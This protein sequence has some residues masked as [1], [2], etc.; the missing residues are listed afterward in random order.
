MNTEEIEILDDEQAQTLLKLLAKQQQ[1]KLR[2]DMDEAEKKITAILKE[3]KL[4][5]IGQPFITDDGRIHT[6][7]GFM[8]EEG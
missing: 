3:H 4:R 8:R 6:R 5:M 1:E 7:I 2:F